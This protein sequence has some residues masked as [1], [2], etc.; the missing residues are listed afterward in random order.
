L[1]TKIAQHTKEC[2]AQLNCA[3]FDLIVDQI[4]SGQEEEEDEEDEEEEEEEEEE[5]NVAIRKTESLIFFVRSS[6]IG[7][8]IEIIEEI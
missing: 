3:S 6:S 5:V 4:E 2:I 1:K 8:F 7:S